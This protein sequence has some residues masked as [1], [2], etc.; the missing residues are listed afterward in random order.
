MIGRERELAAADDFLEGLAE[1]AAALVLEGEPGIG[2]TTLWAATIARAEQRGFRVLSCRPTE[3]EANLSYAAL[4]DLLS[5]LE[6]NAFRFLP[7]PQRRAIDA[8]LL[9][10][11]PLG[12]RVDQLAVSAAVASLLTARAGERPGV[13]VAIDDL[14]WLDSSSA[15][16]LAYAVRRFDS[17][18]VGLLVS[19]R[20]D[21]RRADPLALDRALPRVRR[22]SLGSL[23]LGALRQV[24]SARLGFSPSRPF[25]LRIHR[26]SG[27]NPFFALELAEMLAGEEAS[28][29]G[30]A[31]PLP[32]R[33][34]ALVATRIERLPRRTRRALLLV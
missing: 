24:L 29:I 30:E 21:G 28:L 32:E 20:N 8:A 6:E 26:H 33:L 34:K 18:P 17:S 25:L 5:P 9:R 27:G 7:G 11:D 31:P 2:K 4:A 16:V 3:A 10:T 19:V 1:D 15:R 23:S 22:V 13:L 14:N 12:E